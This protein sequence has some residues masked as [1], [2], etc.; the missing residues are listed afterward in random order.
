MAQFKYKLGGS[1]DANERKFFVSKFR[2][3]QAGGCTWTDIDEA[4][5]WV[6]AHGW[7]FHENAMKRID[8]RKP[9]GPDNLEIVNF[10]R[11]T[12]DIKASCRHY[13]ETVARFK[14]A[15]KAA[16]PTAVKRTLV[17]FGNGETA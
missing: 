17:M 7:V 11:L 12:Q 13:D 9:V 8:S 1:K 6:K 4:Y 5:D 15:L 10:Q 3:W 2:I 16:T 14:A